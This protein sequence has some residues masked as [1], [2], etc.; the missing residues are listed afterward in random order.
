MSIAAR[1]ALESKWNATT[2]PV[3]SSFTSSACRNSSGR[4]VRRGLTTN[5]FDS[6]ANIKLKKAM[7]AARCLRKW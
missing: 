3:I 1:T 2:R 4:L 6:V 7:E 5:F